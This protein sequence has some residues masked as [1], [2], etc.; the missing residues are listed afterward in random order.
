MHVKRALVLGLLTCLAIQAD[1]EKFPQSLGELEQADLIVVGTI[2]RI[3]VE[4]ER[5]RVERA[6]GNYDWG[7]Y[8]TLSV[9]AVEQGQ[10]SHP[11]IEFRCFRI[12]HRRSMMEYLSPSGHRPIPGEGTRT[13]AFLYLRDGQWTAALPNG[14]T[15]PDAEDDESVQFSDLADASAIKALRSRRYT[16]L[17]PLELWIILV[18]VL[19]LLAAVVAGARWIMSRRKRTARSAG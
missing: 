5:S 7:I 8:V 18:G 17:L 13:R 16:Y 10:Y 14:I 4:T 3:R 2:D 11:G 1:A 19:A 9:D 6:F 15:A 12:K